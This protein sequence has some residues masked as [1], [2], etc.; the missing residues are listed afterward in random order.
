MSTKEINLVFLTSL[1]EQWESFH[2]S[3]AHRAYT[4]KTAE[5]FAEVTII[6]DSKASQDSKSTNSHLALH[7][8][9]NDSNQRGK[10]RKFESDSNLNNSEKPCA[11]CRKKGHHIRDCFKKRWKDEQA[12]DDDD[13]PYDWKKA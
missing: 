13:V 1:G 10:K 5:L 11:Y 6:D 3:N 2:Q 12:N 9:F 7:S 4:M 8:K